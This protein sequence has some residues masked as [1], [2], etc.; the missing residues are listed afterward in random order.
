MLSIF[1]DIL[2]RNPNDRLP[3]IT[4]DFKDY[5]AYIHGEQHKYMY[6][7]RTINN[8]SELLKP[9]D[10]II[11]N[12]FIPVLFGTSISP[13]ERELFSQSIKDGGLGL[14]IWHNQADD[15]YMTSKNVTTP[16]QTQILQQTMQL[17]SAYDVNKAKNAA[18]IAMRENE[19]NRTEIII[20]NQNIEMKRNL[21]QLT[22][23]GA[24]SWLSAIPL[25][26][27]GFNLNKSEFNDALCLR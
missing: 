17:P 13:N 24:S 11:T 4:K 5:A 2:Q 14:R 15:S 22:Q 9:I 21:E 23:T 19:K 1:M 16:L 7:L 6:F 18:I 8:T 25:K 3:L 20:E 27:Q 26:E 10:D 12:E